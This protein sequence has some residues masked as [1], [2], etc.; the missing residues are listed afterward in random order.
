MTDEVLNVHSAFLRTHAQY[1]RR[2]RGAKTPTEYFQEYLDYEN[3]SS[4]F[5]D[6]P[7]EVVFRVPSLSP[8]DVMLVLKN[9]GISEG[10]V[11]GESPPR[12]DQVMNEVLSEETTRLEKIRGL[13]RVTAPHVANWFADHPGPQV[14]MKK[15]TTTAVESGYLPRNTDIDPTSK[16]YFL[17]RTP[18]Q[19]I[20]SRDDAPL[21]IPTNETAP[22]YD[23]F[24]VTELAKFRAPTGDWPFHQEESVIAKQYVR[25]EIETV[26]PKLV[27]ALGKR[28]SR[29]L[30]EMSV[31]TIDNAGTDKLYKL[32]EVGERSRF[33][34]TLPHPSYPGADYSPARAAF[35]L[36]QA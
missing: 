10:W 16:Q 31:Q 22:I 36:L 19:E 8:A 26:N 5:S 15:L 33:L 32:T 23:D 25:K 14:R 11:S 21:D 34:L 12:E 13:A 1:M 29:V 2:V 6:Y 30:R 3:P 18:I 27:I 17:P 7:L 20:T 9:P 24:Y 35:D 28:P 4:E